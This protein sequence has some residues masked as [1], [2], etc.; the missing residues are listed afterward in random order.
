[1]LRW[2]VTESKPPQAPSP[3]PLSVSPAPCQEDHGERAGR[4]SGNAL[5]GRRCNQTAPG[6]A[7]C[8]PHAAPLSP[9]APSPWCP[10]LAHLAAC[11]SSHAARTTHLP[12]EG[13]LPPNWKKEHLPPPPP[14]PDTGT[15]AST[16]VDSTLHTPGLDP[17]TPETYYFRKTHKHKS[18]DSP[19]SINPEMTLNSDLR[20]TPQDRLMNHQGLTPAHTYSYW[21]QVMWPFCPPTNSFW[22]KTYLEASGRTDF[23]LH[24]IS[25]TKRE[26]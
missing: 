25:S 13:H 7:P 1:M 14:T 12:I 3:S 4:R 2:L 16:G 26:L 22:N 21:L 19:P 18:K 6:G 20:V 8:G 17:N 11:T 10:L 5:L 15:A 9:A 23:H 24:L